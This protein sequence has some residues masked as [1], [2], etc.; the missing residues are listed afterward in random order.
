MK[1]SDVVKLLKDFNGF[2]AGIEG[3]IVLEYD[4][5]LIKWSLLIPMVKPLML[6]QLQVMY[7]NLWY[8]T[9]AMLNNEYWEPEK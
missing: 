2:S 7:Q 8:T 9:K 5:P 1:Q 6:L 4:E 3:T